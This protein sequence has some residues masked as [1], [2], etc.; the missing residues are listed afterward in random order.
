MADLTMSAY[1]PDTSAAAVILS[2]HGSLEYVQDYYAA[3]VFKRHVRIKILKKAG[4]EW[5]NVDIPYVKAGGAGEQVTDIKA[6]TYNLVNGQ[7]TEDNIKDKEIYD[8]RHSAFVY[9][10]KLAMP[11]VRVGSV[12]E[13]SYTIDS[14][15][16]HN[17][18]EWS[19]QSSIPIVWSEYRVKM[20]ERY[21][22]KM[23][24]Q[25]NQ[26][27]YTPEDLG[28]KHNFR[29]EGNRWIAKDVPALHLESYI[30]T[31]SDYVTKVEFEL[32]K[33]SYSKNNQ[34]VLSGDW[35]EFAGILAEDENFG[36]H[37]KPVG[38]FGT[39][40]A[41]IKAKDT[42]PLQQVEGIYSFVQDSMKWN[43]YHSL[44]LDKTLPEILKKRSG[45]VADINML[46]IAMLREA[47]FNANPVL[48]STR[49]HGKPY[50]KSPL[51]T[52]FDYVVAQ[53]QVDGAEL[54]LDATEPQL[55]PGMLPVRC[56]NGEG[57]LVKGAESKWIPL[58]TG[59]AFSN[60]YIRN[61][62]VD[63]SGKVTG[64]G[65]ELLDGYSALSARQAIKEEGAEKYAATY[66]GAGSFRLAEAIISNAD[67][68]HKPL[69][70]AYKIA[71]D[72]AGS[73]NTIYLNPMMGSGVSKNP[74]QNPVRMYPVD[75]AAPIKET[76]VCNVKLPVGWQVEEVPQNISLTLP[77][78][79]ATYTYMV[80][81]VGNM[82]MIISKLNVNETLF[83]PEEYP[84]LRELYHQAVAKHA[85]QVVLKKE[86]LN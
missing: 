3:F 83:A 25:G 52:K 18:K 10:K 19:F 40:V 26:P 49:S 55:L 7:I 68:L 72:N 58:S 35:D 39:Q 66:S 82:L 15:Y 44:R 23:V 6:S 53:V 24:K 86:A 45:D 51:F 74:F 41:K 31:L 63:N 64:T 11:N 76:V 1:A 36:E 4:Y 22:F 57:Y 80:Q 30:T 77:N 79:S 62:T 81:Q 78:H 9:L 85:E 42:N 70:V 50:K 17:L 16:I 20:P 46:L 21:A 67:S 59:A 14:R 28:L 69:S 56:L 38:R 48:V 65:E 33:V 34:K 5:A 47:G 54:L 61:L 37:L 43:G 2:D 60:Y 32:Y 71:A 8:G 12:I 27:L 13:Y 75:F 73:A 29:K 84:Q